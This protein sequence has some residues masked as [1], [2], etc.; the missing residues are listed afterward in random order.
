MRLA[1]A[2]NKSVVVLTP[3]EVES[4]RFPS[5]KLLVEVNDHNFS[6]HVSAWIAADEL[7]AFVE[8]LTA[9]ERTRSGSACL[10][11]MSPGELSIRFDQCGGMGHFVV[12][13]EIGTHQFTRAGGIGQAVSGSYDLDSERFAE[14]VAAFVD[15]LASCQ[16]GGAIIT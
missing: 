14:V 4:E 9:C 6:G 16:S 15:L 2:D 10:A 1:S 3:Q 8:Q 7:R 13:Y 12:S 11:S 5:V